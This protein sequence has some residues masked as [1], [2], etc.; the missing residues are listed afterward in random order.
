MFFNG[1]TAYTYCP[2]PDVEFPESLKVIDLQNDAGVSCN[3]GDK[4]VL[5]PF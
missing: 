5:S 1:G 4:Q 2:G 3:V